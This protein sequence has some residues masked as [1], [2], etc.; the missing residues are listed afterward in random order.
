M[1]VD[2]IQPAIRDFE[3]LF[4]VCQYTDMDILAHTPKGEVRARVNAFVSTQ[5]DAAN[6]PP[7]GATHLRIPCSH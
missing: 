5:V 3:T 4:L 7:H 2:V 1:V 6:S